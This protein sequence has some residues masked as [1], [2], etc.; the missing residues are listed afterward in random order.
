MSYFTAE[1][2]DFVRELK[3]NNEKE[4]FDANKQ[5]F[6]DHIQ[7][8]AIQFILDFGPELKKI[9]PHF[10]AD[11][12]K[13]GGSLFRIYRNR[14]F[15]PDAPPYKTHVGIQF[16]HDAGKDAHAPG[17]YLHLEPENSGPSDLGTGEAGCFLGLGMWRPDREPLKA[18]RQAIVDDPKAWTA[19]AHAPPFSKQFELAGDS[20]K[21]SPRDFDGDHPLIE[22]IRRK[23]FI[24]T[25]P[26]PMAEVTSD[27][28]LKRFAE[29]CAAGGPF[30]KWMCGAVG[31]AY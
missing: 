1:L 27:D 18:I 13:S 15:Q 29:R 21:T 19:A 17:F 7:E 24:G 11:P 20:L 9:S 10:M 4:W 5:R 23:D 8:P 26:L 6:V 3:Q 28:F 12:R 22:D 14:R 30:L 25:C 16:R 31:V 2:F